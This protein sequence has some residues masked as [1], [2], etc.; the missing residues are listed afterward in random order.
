[1]IAFMESH[2]DAGM[3]SPKVLYPDKV[4]IQFAGAR[5]ISPVTGRGK[6]LG[7]FEKDHGQYNTNYKTDL[8]HGAALIV[9][10]SVVD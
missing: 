7:L 1:I 3:A 4:T 10:R 2:P 8:G 9:R 5:A 6:R